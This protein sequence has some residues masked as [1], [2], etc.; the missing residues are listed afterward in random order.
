M[1][2][3]KHCYI[4]KARSSFSSVRKAFLQL[5]QLGLVFFAYFLSRLF[6]S[7]LCSFLHYCAKPFASQGTGGTGGTGT[8]SKCQC[9]DTPNDS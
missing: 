5:G 8:G 9:H 2:T 1:S 6:G 7:L 4:S 3:G